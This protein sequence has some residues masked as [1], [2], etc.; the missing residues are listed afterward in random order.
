MYIFRGYDNRL[1][2]KYQK[3]NKKVGAKT[4]TKETY[5]EEL[6]DRLAEMDQCVAKKILIYIL[7]GVL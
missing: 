6:L 5:E 3:C 7:A 1:H 2:K 4:K